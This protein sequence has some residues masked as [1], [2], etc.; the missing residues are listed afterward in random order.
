[1]AQPQT[2]ALPLA[3][4]LKGFAQFLSWSLLL[5]ARQIRNLVGSHRS[6]AHSS[7]NQFGVLVAEFAIDQLAV[8]QKA[9]A[10]YLF[11]APL[12]EVQ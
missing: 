5:A 7:S 3:V 12:V 2:W 11:L 1:L 10:L 4:Q 8:Q 6:L 9:L